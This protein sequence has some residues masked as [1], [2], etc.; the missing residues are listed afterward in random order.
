MNA[1]ETKLLLRLVEENAK[2]ETYFNVLAT[3]VEIATKKDRS[4][5]DVD[6]IKP[7]MDAFNRA[8]K[9]VDL[10]DISREEGNVSEN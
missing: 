7:L 8:N 2:L 9:E 1:E 4:Y 5:I 6:E 3:K 10:I